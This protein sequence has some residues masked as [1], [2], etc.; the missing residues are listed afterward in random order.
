MDFLAKLNPIGDAVFLIICL[1]PMAVNLYILRK[2]K[3]ER[4]LTTS[5]FIASFA[6]LI[7]GFLVIYFRN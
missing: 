3:E 1:F 2:P 7:I 6:L 4:K 5:S